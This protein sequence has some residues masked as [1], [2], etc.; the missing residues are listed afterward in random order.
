MKQFK[1][2]QTVIYVSFLLLNIT[3]TSCDN[4]ISD[5]KLIDRE[6]LIFPD[7]SST[8]IPPNIAPLNFRINEKGNFYFVEL[9][10][11]HGKKI[12]IKT[13]SSSI[14]IDINKW[15]KLLNENKGEK[16]RIDIYIQDSSHKWNK[17]NTISNLIAKEDIEGYLAYRLINT[18]YVL[19]MK[20]GLYQRN[21][22][23]FDE[24]AIFENSSADQACINCHS[25]CKNDPSKMM[26][27]IR[28]THA[29]TIILNNN[30]LSKIN[31]KTKYSMAAGAY[32]SWNPDGIHI[33]YSVNQINQIFTSIKGKGIEVFDKASDIVVLNTETNVLTTSPK[34]SSVRRENLPTWSPDGKTLYFISAPEAKSVEDCIHSKYSLLRI[35]FDPKTN[36][37]GDV[38]T[39]ISSHKTGMSISF[40]RISPNGRF[41]MFCMSDEGYFTIHH[42]NTDLFMMDLKS[43]EYHKLDINSNTTDSYHCWSQS[44]HW[45]V[46]SSKRIDKLYT[47]PFFSYVDDS[48]KAYKP[49]I[50]PQKDPSFY[51][52]FLKNYNIPELNTGKITV[53][54]N[55]FRDKI[56]EE[57]ITSTFDSKVDFDALSGATKMV[58]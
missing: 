16:L 41:L 56:F 15:K 12:Q 45:F 18:G 50:L 13:S 53:S 47:R 20:M 32:P 43:G 36:I 49:F 3:L 10:S 29:G 35:P 46:F 48:G 11:R 22:E 14:E 42:A 2:I 54:P 7:Y 31:T 34:I 51:E 27:H 44:N 25:F 6:P 58:K 23:N 55:T 8:V 57:A 17:Y 52:N 37:W 33:A 4:K 28:S 40:P 5:F 39:V 9:Y 19:W 26:F 38:D 1:N 30:N 24:S 21:L